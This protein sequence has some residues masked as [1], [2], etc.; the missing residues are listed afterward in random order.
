[1]AARRNRAE[2]QPGVGEVEVMDPLRKFPARS[3]RRRLATVRLLRRV[4]PPFG[5]LFTGGVTLVP[6][7]PEYGL[8]LPLVE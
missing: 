6:S 4:T 8:E 1:M 7:L 5:H 3:G 2:V